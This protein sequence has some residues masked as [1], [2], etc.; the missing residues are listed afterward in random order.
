MRR[1]QVLKESRV[2]IPYIYFIERGLAA[3]QVRT[4]T[5]GAHGIGLLGHLSMTGLPLVLGTERSPLRVVVQTAGE[6]YRLKVADA[7]VLFSRDTAL[8][9][10]ALGYV[11]VRMVQSA[12]VALCNAHH[13][14]EHRVRRWLL[15]AQ[16]LLG[17][18][19]IC[20]SHAAIAS[21]LGVRRPSVS[22]HVK[23][24]EQAGLVTQ[25]FACITVR[26]RAGLEQGACECHRLV[27]AEYQRLQPNREWAPHSF[28]KAAWA[29]AFPQEQKSRGLT[30]EGTRRLLRT[31]LSQVGI[32]VVEDDP[33][34]VQKQASAHNDYGEIRL[35]CSGPGD[36]ASRDH[37]GEVPH[38]VIPAE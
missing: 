4:Q 25:K 29:S 26:D 37:D 16:S 19:E 34:G 7:E 28:Q 13:S 24:L 27:W 35:G 10:L 3:L 5:D 33:R 2:D 18:D 11:Q 12:Q 22:E 32:G 1:R 9:R 23:R 6:A 14:V 21:H 17:E 31:G 8:R 20:V 30:R 15:L 36:G 38:G